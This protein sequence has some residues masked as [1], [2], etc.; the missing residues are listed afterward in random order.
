MLKR[1]GEPGYTMVELLM[2]V[3]ILGLVAGAVAG[4]YEVSQQTYIRAAGLEDAQLG[5]RAGLD[6]MVDE[7]QLAGAYWSGARDAGTAITAATPGGITFM[8][9]VD[10]DTLNT[11]GQ[12][13]TLTAPASSGATSITVDRTTGDPGG[14]A[15]TAGE[16]V[17]IADGASREV[18]QIAAGYSNGTTIQ[19]NPQTPL[20]TASFPTAAIVRS[21]EQVAYGTNAGSLTRN[22]FATIDNVTGLTLAY[23]DVNG[24][25]L[26]AA[27]TLT[28]IRTIQ[29]T[30]TTQGADGS[31][32]TMT[33]RVLARNL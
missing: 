29:I 26:G 14:N 10:A 9:D 17:Y 4:V 15:F 11:A 21:V 31:R 33:S 28:Q 27:P 32:R 22:G 30:L 1:G 24:T 19:L 18:K 3:A 6:R 25:N 2:A 5:A 7:L 12:E 13:I 23:F 8:A 20:K 16:W